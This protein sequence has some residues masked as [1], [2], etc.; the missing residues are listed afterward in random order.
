MVRIIFS[1]TLKATQGVGVAGIDKDF[2]EWERAVIRCACWLVRHDVV[3]F[4]QKD[5]IEL[6]PALLGD[7]A[8]QLGR[9]SEVG[10]GSI[11]VSRSSFILIHKKGDIMHIMVN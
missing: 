8:E 7:L 11:P 2:S 9:L 1:R 6:V 4:N 5:S 10:V 3:F